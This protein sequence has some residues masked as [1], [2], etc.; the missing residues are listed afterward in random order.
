MQLLGQVCRQNLTSGIYYQ[1]PLVLRVFAAL[2]ISTIPQSHGRLGAA[3]SAWSCFSTRAGCHSCD[4]H[5][6]EAKP[7]HL[8]HLKADTDANR[9]K[10]YLDTLGWKSWRKMRHVL[11][12]NKTPQLRPCQVTWTFLCSPSMTC[13]KRGK[14]GKS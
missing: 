9:K 7:G 14:A 8:D 4:I 13:E 5:D 11:A 6:H 12:L 2:I 10:L 1:H 3:I